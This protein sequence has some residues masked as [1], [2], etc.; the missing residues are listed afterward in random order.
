MLNAIL[1]VNDS[2]NIRPNE[3]K[4]GQAEDFRVHRNNPYAT[5][6]WLFKGMDKNRKQ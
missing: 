2:G 1:V 3:E 5:H 6:S 4:H